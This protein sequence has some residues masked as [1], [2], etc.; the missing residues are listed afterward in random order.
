MMFILETDNIPRTHE[1]R[2][3][4]DCVVLGCLACR[5]LLALELRG[6]KSAYCSPRSRVLRYFQRV[7]QA[8]VSVSHPVDGGCCWNREIAFAL[9]PR[10][11]SACAPTLL[12]FRVGWATMSIHLRTT[13]DLFRRETRRLRYEYSRIGIL[14]DGAAEERRS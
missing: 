5:M 7:Q 1:T 9:G 12:T 3:F 8:N 13:Q 10:A 4:V 11:R 14:Y 2:S 6:K